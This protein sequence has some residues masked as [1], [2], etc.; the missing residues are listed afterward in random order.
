MLQQLN[1]FI[2][3]LLGKLGGKPEYEEIGET[4]IKGV[5]PKRRPKK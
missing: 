2:N 1:D 3:G 4:L 5:L